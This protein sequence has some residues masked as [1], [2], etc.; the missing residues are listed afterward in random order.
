MDTNE[1]QVEEKPWLKFLK[2]LSNDTQTAC[3]DNIEEGQVSW[4]VKELSPDFMC[5]EI[6]YRE[7]ENEDFPVFHMSVS[8]R[9]RG[10]NMICLHNV[11]TKKSHYMQADPE[12]ILAWLSF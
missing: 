2:Q 3:T 10:N 11:S 6:T 1:S 5:V 4:N 9:Y 8:S 7:D 12:L